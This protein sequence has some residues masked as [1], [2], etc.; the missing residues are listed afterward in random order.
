MKLVKV[1]L[2]SS[3]LLFGGILA[4]HLSGGSIAS[5]GSISS[6]L[7]LSLLLAVLL[8]DEEASDTKL[9]AAVFIAQNGA[10][11]LMGG[12]MHES[13]SMYIGHTIAGVLTFI[14]ISKS[15][16]ILTSIESLLCFLYSHLI[17]HAIFISQLIPQKAVRAFTP[18]LPSFKDLVHNT[19]IS[20]R[21]P[22]L[23]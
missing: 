5:K 8:V 18:Y 1:T 9:F 7:I 20:L 17:P 11:F 2:G 22:P 15:S 23:S 12:S 4:H 13:F 3:L 14:F 19:T 10:H 21:A 6:F 16:E